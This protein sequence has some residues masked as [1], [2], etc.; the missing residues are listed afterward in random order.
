LNLPLAKLQPGDV[1]RLI[2]P[3]SPPSEERIANTVEAL[4][5]I[6]FVVEIGP[7]ARAR[8][9]FMAGSDEQRLADIDDAL[10]DPRIRALI[11]TSG[12]KGAHRIA[13]RIDF[14]AA[15]RDP[16]L[17]VGFSDLTI[18]HLALWKHCGVAGLHAA[19]WNPKF[20][21]TSAASFRAAITS[22]DPVLIRSRPE[23]STA[24]LT[25]SGSARGILIGGNLDLIGA[26]AGWVLPDLKGAILLIEAANWGLGHLDRIL[27]RLLNTG[28]I[29]GL[30]G[31]AVGQFT[32]IEP[33]SGWT[34]VEV[35]RDRLAP[36][37]VPILG[38]LPLGHGADP[39]AVPLG[40][41]AMLNADAGTLMVASPFV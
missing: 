26:A 8:M 7:H 37:G 15:R 2:S 19:A 3:A 18:L 36:L 14:A 25:T 17:L 24:V 9:G 22:A 38:G 41:E 29:A 6:G 35:L 21:A 13:D 20:S 28:A 40:T 5:D 23:E 1:V 32:D 10:R 12:G 27:T 34:E 4:E 39:L 33:S 16:K 11:A 30:T 31:V